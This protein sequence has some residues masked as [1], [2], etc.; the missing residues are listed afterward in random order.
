MEID[1]LVGKPL[2][3][4]HLSSCSDPRN[5]FIKRDALAASVIPIFLEGHRAPS[6][7]LEGHLAWS[8]QHSGEDEKPGFETWWKAEATSEKLPS[9]C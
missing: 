9:D 4:Q 1:V 8:I 2:A 7:K 6:W 5:S 3:I